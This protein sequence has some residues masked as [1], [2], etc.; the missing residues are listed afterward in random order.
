MT[1]GF[2]DRLAPHWWQGEILTEFLYVSCVTLHFRNFDWKSNNSGYS[3]ARGDGGNQMTDVR[4]YVN[5][6]L[7]TTI[8]LRYR[9]Y[10]K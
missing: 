2:V 7:D 5:V 10:C 8:Y 3:F 9:L 6:C 4:V 1:S